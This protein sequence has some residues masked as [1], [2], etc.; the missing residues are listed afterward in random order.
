VSAGAIRPR[1]LELSPPPRAAA[2][3]A[4][5]AL[6]RREATLR[7]G[8]TLSLAGIA[9]VEAIELPSLWGQGRPFALAMAAMVLCIV[10]A[11]APAAAPAHA[12]RP[13]WR[14]VAAVAVVVL[15]GWAVPRAVA[16]P[17]TADARG[18]WTSMPGAAC[19]A[20]AAVSLMLAAAAG[21]PTRATAGGLATAV[22][23]V[24]AIGPL[25]GA[26]LV[27]VEPGPPGG[28]SA[29]IAD[30]HVHAHLTTGES[31]IVFRPGRSGNHYLTPVAT[32]P[33]PPAIGVALVAGV[34]FAFV[35]GAIGQLRRR[36][37]R[38]GPDRS[39]A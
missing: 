32:P 13:L 39:L 27:A 3:D 26:L 1:A 38:P 23:L 14:T 28:E 4:A 20:L 12:S 7:A 36:C 21:R 29:I 35:L 25:V 11:F 24:L 18:A 9:L 15:A 31:D 8:A 30:V 10:V 17:D 34:A 33:R 16:L 5:T 2:L 37:A 22:A 19:A 6:T